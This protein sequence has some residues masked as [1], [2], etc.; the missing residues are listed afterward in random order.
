MVVNKGE[1]YLSFLIDVIVSETNWIDTK[2]LCCMI[3]S[4][5]HDK[6]CWQAARCTRCC[7]ARGI[8][9]T[10]SWNNLPIWAKIGGITCSRSLHHGSITI[11]NICTC[12]C[13]PSRQTHIKIKKI[14]RQ[15]R[16]ARESMVRILLTDKTRQYTGYL[17][18]N[19]CISTA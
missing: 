10:D 18:D 9:L 8:C 19:H 15:V 14:Y 12:I 7:V 16:M 17:E 4:S 1:I 13:I 3:H 5:F 11:K 2:D 6:N